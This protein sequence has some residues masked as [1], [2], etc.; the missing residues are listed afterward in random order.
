MRLTA[1]KIKDKKESIMYRIGL[2][3]CKKVMDESLFEDYAKNGISLMEVSPDYDKY[4]LVDY[5]EL[6]RLSKKY[7]VELWSYHLPFYLPGRCLD[8]SN[9][10]HSADVVEYYTELMKKAADIGVGKMVVHPGGEGIPD[11][12]RGEHIKRA[13][14]SL[15]V[16]AQTAKEL[17]CVIC[18]EDLPRTCIGNTI[19]EMKELVSA[20]PDLR[21]CFDTNHLM[22]DSNVDFV[23]TFGSTIV[24]THVSDYDPINER[25]WLPGEGM[26]DW[27]SLMAALA[28][29]D[30]G[31]A[32]L[33]EVDFACPPTIIRDRDLTCADFSR[34]A[35]E[36]FEGRELTVFSSP[37]P[38]V[39]FWE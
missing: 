5:A 15:A 4:H 32:W 39:G 24:T 33:Y 18:V 35:R 20:H 38:N 3:T 12:S 31:G 14:E 13:K 25:H 2:S 10:E 1:K 16:L 27:R 19:A 26:T 30:Y 22:Q 17:G 11:E 23:R 21:I 7:G 29:V 6:F 36:L 37:K 8:I 28:D 9:T 34:N